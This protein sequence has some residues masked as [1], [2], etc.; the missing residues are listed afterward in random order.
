MILAIGGIIILILLIEK[1]KRKG[2]M[3]GL[4]VAMGLAGYIG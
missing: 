4:I 1:G 2:K 3:K